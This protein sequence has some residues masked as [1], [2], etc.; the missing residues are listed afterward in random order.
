[1]MHPAIYEALILGLMGLSGV[2]LGVLFGVRQ[3][4]PLA[5]TALGV[6]VS[7]R[8]LSAF[9]AWS[10]STAHLAFDYWLWASAVVALTGL[11]ASNKR[12]REVFSGLAVFG[13]ASVAA[14][15]TKY[16][17]DI[18]ERHHSD[19]ADTVALALVAIQSET[20]D[21]SEIA[22]SP[23]RGIAYPLMLALGPSG[24]ILGGLTPLI[25]ILS[26]LLVGWLVWSLLGADRSPR[27]FVISAVALGAFSLSV[28]MFRA[29]F[30]YLNGHTL[31]ALGLLLMATAWMMLRETQNFSPASAL[32]LATGGVVGVTA[33][34]EGIVLVLILVAFVVSERQWG[35]V[36][37]RVR[38]GS[39]LAVIGISVT[40]WFGSL[41]S[42]VL[43][44]FGVS[45]WWLVGLTAVGAALA[46][47]SWIDPLRRWI[48]PIVAVVL[49]A[50]LLRVVISS[51]DPL[52][53]VLAQWPNLGL[54][55]GGWATAAHMFIGSMVLI[56][57]TKRS[58]HFRQLLFV[59]ALVI[60]G[61]LFTKTFDGGFGGAG[62][63]D[64]VNRM[65]LHVMP[66]VMATSLLGY[67]ELLGDIFRQSQ[68][69]RYARRREPDPVTSGQ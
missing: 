18:G 29:S 17:F 19:S 35:G 4:I 68:Q 31:M 7:I 10:T 30:F 33:R 45:V 1:M 52:G 14:L 25:M 23:K 55:A 61:I 27:A 21:L 50:L 9:A 28:P 69:P 12:W 62:F 3:A 36:A 6:G 24:R 42:P 11:I 65:W 32:M 54:G 37:S 39:A 57:L 60:G 53:M 48:T 16:L 13:A 49:V 64:S 34:A 58:K 20:A 26:V 56:G 8:A 47:V 38:L 63:Y 15:A 44:R 59:S 51:G 66:L 40:W 67:S 46:S 2:S 22:N 43:D 41:S 5:A